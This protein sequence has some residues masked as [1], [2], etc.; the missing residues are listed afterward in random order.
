MRF[1]REGATKTARHRLEPILLG[2][3]PNFGMK[4]KS[5]Q[6]EGTSQ[7]KGRE[8]GFQEPEVS[9]E[10]QDADRENERGQSFTEKGQNK[11][12]PGRERQEACSNGFWR[13]AGQRERECGGGEEES[14]WC[15]EQVTRCRLEVAHGGEQNES[16]RQGRG[17][18]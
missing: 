13:G 5:P 2:K 7:E 18:G 10:Q 16:S 4:G 1:Q 11:K 15:I 17:S 12:H 3:G 8:V 6:R 9:R 14:Q